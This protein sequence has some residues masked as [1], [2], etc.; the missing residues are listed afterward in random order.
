MIAGAWVGGRSQEN[1]VWMSRMAGVK[2]G[3]VGDGREA[4]TKLPKNVQC[5]KE[6]TLQTGEG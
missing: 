4:I 2:A 1:E 6:I 5:A 3:Y